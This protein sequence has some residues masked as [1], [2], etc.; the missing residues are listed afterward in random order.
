MDAAASICSDRG[1]TL[2]DTSNLRSC[3]RISWTPRNTAA[4]PKGMGMS[5]CIVVWV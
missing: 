2:G 5:E 3:G 1:Q 4:G